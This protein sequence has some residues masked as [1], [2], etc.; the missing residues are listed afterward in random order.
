[1][2][3]E[4]E[5][6]LLCVYIPKEHTETV[7]SALFNAGAGRLGN[8]DQCMWKTSGTGR[9]RPR[10]GSNPFKGTIDKIETVQEDKVEIIIPLE[11]KDRIK[12]VLLKAHPYETPAYHFIEIRP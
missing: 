6:Y 5:F 12:S 7:I 4:C 10:A 1:M 11:K 2:H 8:Y 3:E 9:F